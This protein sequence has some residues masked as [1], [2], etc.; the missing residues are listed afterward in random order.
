MVEQTFFDYL[1]LSMFLLAGLVFI[2]LM[3]VDAPYGKFTRP[4]FGPT[5]NRRLGWI[6]ME[7][8][9]VALFSF[10]FAT[11]D[12]SRPGPWAGWILFGMWML[13]YVHRAF[14]F[15]FRLR[16]GSRNM[17]VL[18]VVLGFAFTSANS[19]LN[20]GWLYKLG[21]AGRP[22]AA[23]EP[24]FMLGA[25]LF[26]A[27]FALNQHSDAILISLRKPGETG[28]KIPR[29]GAFELV[30]CP[31]YLGE[32]IEWLGWAIATWSLPG[33]A[34]FTWTAANLAPRALAQHRWYRQEFKDDYPRGRKALLP[35]IL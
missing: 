25:A 30:S 18:A 5:M 9:S 20:A 8:P 1:L 32:M 34:F 12:S 29:G 3:F 21:P 14:V 26:L 7:L 10:F 11:G 27:G 22:G 4:G 31:N 6:I 24:S 2:V 33:L 13:H 15:P 16:G 17:T 23:L 35:F 28:Y 19:Y